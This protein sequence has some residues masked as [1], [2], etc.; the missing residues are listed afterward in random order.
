[1][2]IQQFPERVI[3]TSK[4]FCAALFTS[5]ECH[6]YSIL[7]FTCFCACQKYLLILLYLV[8]SKYA[9]IQQQ[10][11]PSIGLNVLKFFSVPIYTEFLFDLYKK[12]QV[13]SINNAN[14]KYQ[15]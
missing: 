15:I 9:K 12:F 5:Y 10:E 11:V 6:S 3:H 7:L 14:V 4:Y 8:Q 1:M 2:N 13:A